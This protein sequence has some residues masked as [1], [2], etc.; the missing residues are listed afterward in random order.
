M[1]IPENLQELAKQIRE[2]QVPHKESVRTL[3]GWF[4]A[5]RRGSWV[6]SN[7]RSALANVELRTNPNFDEVYID[8]EVQFEPIP[9]HSTDVLIPNLLDESGEVLP[10]KVSENIGD[11]V[12]R[13][14]MLEAANRV[15][16]SVGRD[17]TVSQAVTLMLMND[18]SQ[19]PVMQGERDVKG[20]I[21]WKSI[22]RQRALGK[23]C[24]YVRDC[25]EK[26]VIIDYNTS[27][28]ETVGVIS[29]KEVVLV[30]G[31]GQEIVGL[32]T[33]SDISVQFKILSEAFIL[34]GEIENHIRRILNGKFSLETLQQA[35]DPIDQNRKQVQTISNL[36]FGE[37]IRLLENPNNWEKLLLDLDRSLFVERLSEIR[38]IRNEVMHFH[39]DGISNRDL[40]KLRDTV[41]FM[42]VLNY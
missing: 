31:R 22:G 20:M 32:I 26:P 2:T 28:F 15:P 5:Q 30:R 13:V 9:L 10:L 37:Y 35:V 42:Q 25:M 11:P 4:G 38:D 18:F 7:I 1:D 16:I 12:F 34:V 24:E 6:V 14:E 29:Q 19:L 39:P 8:Y 21:S 40:D 27:L 3:L 17:S 36:T 23:D 33:T 41:S